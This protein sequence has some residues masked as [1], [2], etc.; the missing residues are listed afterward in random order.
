MHLQGLQ[1]QKTH[2]YALNFRS[3]LASDR[4]YFLSGL[5]LRDSWKIRRSGTPDGQQPARY[6]K[7]PD[8]TALI[9]ARQQI[10][11]SIAMS[12][13]GGASKLVLCEGDPDAPRGGVSSQFYCNVLEEGLGP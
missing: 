13:E 5:E 3:G 8:L 4:P 11:G 7:I 9:R 1:H 6:A 12:G 2:L 10:G